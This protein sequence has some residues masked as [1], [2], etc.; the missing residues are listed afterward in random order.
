VILV[1]YR[2]EHVPQ[3]HQWMLDP[4]LRENTASELLSLEE[5]YENQESWN[6]DP[7]KLSFIILDRQLSESSNEAGNNRNVE[8]MV[9]DCNLFFLNHHGINQENEEA[10]DRNEEN[11]SNCNPNYSTAEIEIM[12][13]EKKS[14]RNG[15][16]R[17]SLLMLMNYTIEKLQ[18]SR[19]IAK[20]GEKNTASL[21]LFESLGFVFSGQVNVFHEVT[22]DLIV[23]LERKKFISN[24]IS[25]QFM[26]LHYE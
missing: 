7:T 20:I 1:P 25:G 4:E 2:K 6:E 21:R 11:L 9:G 12:I 26:E 15:L 3:Y 17:E 23:S 19:F 22:M 5:E 10:S 13:A 14:R 8:A 24:A 18:V 16:A